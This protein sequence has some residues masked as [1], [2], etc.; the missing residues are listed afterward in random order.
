MAV[1]TGLISMGESSVL[2]GGQGDRMQDESLER[3]V[4]EKEM[5]RESDE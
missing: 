4:Q 3:D 1:G 5:E 2:V